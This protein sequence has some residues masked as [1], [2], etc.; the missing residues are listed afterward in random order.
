[1]TKAEIELDNAVVAQDEAR[2]S[3]AAIL[4]PEA[5]WLWSSGSD[6]YDATVKLRKRY[7]AA[8]ARVFRAEASLAKQYGVAA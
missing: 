5:A 4:R 3:L 1:M 6:Y 8:E 7:N 2:A